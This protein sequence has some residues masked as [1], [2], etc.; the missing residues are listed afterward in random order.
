MRCVHCTGPI[1]IGSRTC[2]RCGQARP[3][4][5]PDFQRAENHCLAL[6][7][8]LQ[9]GGIDEATFRSRLHTLTFQDEGGR[10][11]TLSPQGEWYTAHGQEWVQKDPTVLASKTPMREGEGGPPIAPSVRSSTK[12]RRKWLWP[13]VGCGG[14]A[15]IILV[16]LAYTLIAG[17]DDYHSSPM[18]VE[19]VEAGQAI[20]EGEVLTETQKD[21][22]ESRGYPEAFTLLFD[23]SDR[24]ET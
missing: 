7:T 17:Y 6:K 8:R 11:W 18:L 16:L 3:S 23:E 10:Y 4:L 5:P 19:E 2:P 21:V 24:Y 15:L 22:L 1:P 13:T 20:P 12:K 9:S 14:L